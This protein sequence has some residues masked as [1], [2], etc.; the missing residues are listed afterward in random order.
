MPRTRQE[1]KV[2]PGARQQ[3]CWARFNVHTCPWRKTLTCLRPAPQLLRTQH[4]RFPT[5]HCLMIAMESTPNLSSAVERRV[6]WSII[7]SNMS[8]VAAKPQDNKCKLCMKPSKCVTNRWLSSWANP[9]INASIHIKCISS[10]HNAG[11]LQPI[12][13]T[14]K[15]TQVSTPQCF[16]CCL[17]P[18]K[19]ALAGK[20]CIDSF[21]VLPCLMPMNGSLHGTAHACKRDLINNFKKVSLF[22]EVVAP[23]SS[24]PAT[25]LSHFGWF[26]LLT[27][28]IVRSQWG[29]YN[30][31]IYIYIL[32]YIYQY[33]YKKK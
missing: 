27:M 21:F 32:F 23:T 6:L 22:S 13:A 19:L 16:G 4:E 28:I 30:L 7:D 11:Y 18:E 2:L 9:H 10:R 1:Q 12:F 8:F 15:H 29:R 24:N 3:C 31:P 33:I 5:D 14:K 25:A 20:L 17:A 26:P